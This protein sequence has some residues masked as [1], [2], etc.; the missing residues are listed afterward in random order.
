MGPVEPVAPFGILECFFLFYNKDLEN[1]NIVKI[2][3]PRL[4]PLTSFPI[5]TKS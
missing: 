1:V 2:H 3:Q 4:I 5:K